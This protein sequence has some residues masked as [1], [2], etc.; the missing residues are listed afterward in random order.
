[1]SIEKELISRS[2][3]LCELCRH[4]EQLS[5][6]EVTPAQNQGSDGYALLCAACREQID[7][8]EQMDPAH[9][10]CLNDSMWSEIPAVKVLSWRA[11]YRLRDEGWSQDLLDMMYLEEDTLSWAKAEAELFMEEQIVHKDSNGAVLEAGD[12]VTLIQD[13]KVKGAGLTAKRG[14]AV[15]RISLDPNNAAYIEG[16]VDGQHI[17]ILTQYVKK[18]NKS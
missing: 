15:R 2:G 8:P 17:V 10:R 4:A 3:N 7:Q 13:L 5:A 11:L 9:W 16:K 12:T 18:V 1:M 14:T 6:Y